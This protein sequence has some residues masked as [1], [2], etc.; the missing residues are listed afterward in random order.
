QRTFGG[1]SFVLDG[2]EL[3]APIVH[4][5]RDPLDPKFDD[6]AFVAAMHRR[7]T[8]V[9]RALLDQT[10]VSGIGNIYADE[11]LWRARLHYARPTETLTRP[12]IIRLLESVRAVLQDA[13]TAGG[14][15][16]DALYVDVNGESGYFD[17]ALAVY[18]RESEPCPRCGSPVRR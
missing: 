8:G 5:A 1:L 10:L 6:A 14:T 18:G 17:R 12:G 7:H 13:L 4:I 11:A 3:P 9:K 2:A 15:S 16:F